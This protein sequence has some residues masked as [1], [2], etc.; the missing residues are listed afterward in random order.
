[1]GLP[2]YGEAMAGQ[3]VAAYPVS[4]PQK[5]LP[6]WAVVAG[7]AAERTRQLCDRIQ[8]LA[9]GLI[10]QLPE[11]ASKDPAPPKSYGGLLGDVEYLSEKTL[12][13]VQRAHDFLD[14]I[15]THVG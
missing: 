15:G 14:R 12:R 4:T 2:H 13:R 9:D 10:G 1:M 6:H 11:A 8:Q 7:Q 3:T 5:S